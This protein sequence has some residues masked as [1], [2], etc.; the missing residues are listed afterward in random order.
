MRIDFRHKNLPVKCEI[1]DGTPKT[2]SSP[3][4]QN[5]TKQAIALTAFSND[6]VNICES[7]LKEILQSMVLHF[8]IVTLR[9]FALFWGLQCSFVWG[10]EG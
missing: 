1:M 9:T 10:M 4:P 2:L 3:T 8:T 7:V 5:P 6:A